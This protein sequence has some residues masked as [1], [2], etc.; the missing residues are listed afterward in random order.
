MVSPTKSSLYYMGGGD[1]LGHLASESW[2]QYDSILGQAMM[3]QVYNPCLTIG[4]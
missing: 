1:S 3:L 4:L 2:G